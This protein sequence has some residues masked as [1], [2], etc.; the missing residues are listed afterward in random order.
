MQSLQCTMVSDF[1]DIT[2]ERQAVL[3]V[4]TGVVDLTQVIDDEE[5]SAKPITEYIEVRGRT[6]PV[7]YDGERNIRVSD[8]FLEE[9]V[10]SASPSGFV[11]QSARPNRF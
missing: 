4:K 6:E 8:Q 2:I 3:N 5:L 9:L 1:K 7:F 10:A 11:M